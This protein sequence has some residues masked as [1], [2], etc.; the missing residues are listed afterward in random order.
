MR[1]NDLGFFL[2]VEGLLVV[3]DI[4]LRKFA[5]IMLT[6][7]REQGL[8]IRVTHKAVHASRLSRAFVASRQCLERSVL[9][10]RLGG[11]GRLHT[12]LTVIFTEA[13]ILLGSR[14]CVEFLCRLRHLVPTVLALSHLG[15]SLNMRSHSVILLTCALAGLRTCWLLTHSGLVHC[16]EWVVAR[17][18]S[19]VEV[20]MAS[21]TLYSSTLL[22]CSALIVVTSLRHI[23]FIR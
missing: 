8:G 15:R 19:V 3:F 1:I 20:L 13:T 2:Q 11:S 17:K 7:V 4:S 12:I 23:D 9:P 21:G 18:T 16:L 22:R 5:V 6:I 14:F 10:D